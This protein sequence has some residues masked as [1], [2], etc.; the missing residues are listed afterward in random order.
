MRLDSGYL[1]IIN[2]FLHDVATG[3]WI[4]CGLVIW[5]LSGRVAGIP[6]EA[7]AALGSAM[8]AVFNL[9]LVSLVVVGATGGVRLGYWRRETDAPDIAKKRR[10]LLVKHGTF[11]LVYGLGTAWF[12][13]L[14]RGA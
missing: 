6:A 7:A 9:A 10:A 5:L 11:F 13:M 3:T 1:R 8:L 14:V 4:A 12:W 2:N